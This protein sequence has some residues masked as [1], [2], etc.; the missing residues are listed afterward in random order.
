MNEDKDARELHRLYNKHE[1]WGNQLP[2]KETYNFS[3]VGICS[4]GDV[5]LYDKV[6]A[7]WEPL[8]GSGLAAGII[9]E[10]PKLYQVLADYHD[11]FPSDAKVRPA[12]WAKIMDLVD[13]KLVAPQAPV[14]SLT[15]LIEYLGSKKP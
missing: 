6:A 11:S 2:I 8:V 10:H 3:H 4:C 5:F 15:G 14:L 9:E 12:P 13:K 1:P 7:H